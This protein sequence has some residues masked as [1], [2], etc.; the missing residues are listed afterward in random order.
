MI[1]VGR[2]EGY[3]TLV[4]SDGDDDESLKHSK[5]CA[6]VA[7]LRNPTQCTIYFCCLVSDNKGYLLTSDGKEALERN[8]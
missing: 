8:M 4:A 2:S 1:A 6:V 7:S 5:S 3:G